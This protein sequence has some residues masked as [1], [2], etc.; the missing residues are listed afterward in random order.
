[1]SYL[2]PRAL[3]CLTCCLLSLW[4]LSSCAPINKIKHET[5]HQT[6]QQAALTAIAPQASL[7]VKVEI[8]PEPLLEGIRADDIARAQASSKKYILPHW[9]RIS[10]RSIMLRHRLVNTLQEMHAPLSLQL[11]PV[12]ESGYQPYALSRTGAMGLWQLMPGTARGLGIK[13]NKYIDGRRH[14]EQSTRAAVRYLLDQHKRFGNWPL[15]FAAYNMGPNGLSRRL[16]KTPWKLSDGLA[17]I[18]APLE[19]RSYVLHIIGLAALMQMNTM[20]FEDSMTTESITLQAPVDIAQLTK[21]AKLPTKSLFQMNPS[22]HYSQY[23]Q[24]DINL[25]IPQGMADTLQSINQLQRPKYIKIHIRSGDSLWKLA[26]QY[27]TSIAQLRRLNSKLP[28]P[29]KIGRTITVPAH[30]L[31]RATATLNPLL[32]QG[33]RIRYKVRKGDSLWAISKRFGTTTRAIARAN[34]L[35]PRSLIRPG[36]TL[37]ILAHIRPS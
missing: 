28:N 18:P 14:I 11:I 31:S 30:G 34:Q 6:K 21:A 16:K 1:M 24:K 15:A 33:R 13:P 9:S 8:I 23:L 29:L 2:F 22:L 37:W 7:K 19:T 20:K 4:M 5:S 10:T 27:H 36:D 17:K 35:S 3:A 32:T 12:V 25:H 26:R